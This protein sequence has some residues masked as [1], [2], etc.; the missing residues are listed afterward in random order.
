[1]KGEGTQGVESYM[2]HVAAAASFEA[3]TRQE[4]DPLLSVE[5][6]PESSSMID[7]KS[8]ARDYPEK[9]LPLLK[10]L[11]PEFQELFAEYWLLGKSQSFIGR[12]H[13]FIQTRVWQNLRII[14]Q[15]IGA[16]I[17][18]GTNPDAE[19]LRPILQKA[20]LEDTAYGSLTFMILKYAEYQDYA[21]V[22]LRVGAPVPAVR[23][24]FRPA[25]TALLADRSVRAV[26]VGAYLRSLTHQASLTGAGLSKR[27]KARNRRVKALHFTAPPSETSPLLSF[28]RVETL[29]ETPWCMLEISSDHRMAQIG[30]TLRSQ[31][32]RIFEKRPGQIFA[33]LT[34]D[35]ELT[36]GYIFARSTALSLVRKL[37]HIRGI[38]E[39]A[40]ICNSEGDFIHAVLVPNKEIQ[41]LLKTHTVIEDP[42]VRPQDFVEILTGDAARYCGTITCVNNITDTVTVEV[43]FPTGRKF[44]VKAEQTSV[45]K[46]PKTPVGQRAFWG[47][48]NF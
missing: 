48:L 26:A 31:G 1:M 4:V 35:G 46:L 30:P 25:I 37:V 39:L 44:I 13:G 10:Q 47:A 32:K 5:T 3:F 14:E 28:G 7:F 40:T 15:S 6:S 27:C 42:T 21:N 19:I 17:L 38:A 24:I 11:R 43:V 12:V 18:L 29:G 16:L 23:K 2:E 34:A 9:L 8:F 36:L 41:E 22:A 45:K 20:N 33:P